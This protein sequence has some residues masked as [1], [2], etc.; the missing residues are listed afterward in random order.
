MSLC[1]IMRV[2]KRRRASVFGLQ[3]EANREAGDH[4]IDGRDFE[5]SDID[6]SRTSENVSL[7]HTDNWNKTI[8]STLHDLGIKERKDSVVLLD[9]LYTASPEFFEGKDREQIIDYFRECLDF[10]ER[11]YGKAINA[12]IHLDE[13]T[14]HLQ[15]ASIP[16]T[17][18]EKGYHLSAKSI[19]GGRA[20]Y[21]ARQDKFWNDVARH[22]GL[23][24]G[25]VSEPGK[26]KEH[27][28]VLAY[29]TATARTKAVEAE[30]DLKATE[31]RL[32]RAKSI[33]EASDASQ[34]AT[35]HR[36]ITGKE[37]MRVSPEAYRAIHDARSALQFAQ[38]L[39]R[40]P[41]A[42]RK[43]MEQK[44][45]K[46]LAVA[47]DDAERIRSEAEQVRRQ[48]EQTLRE[49]ESTLDRRNKKLRRY[50]RMERHWPE[51][52]K[53]MS[54]QL[55]ALDRERDNGLGR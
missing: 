42:Y 6:W 17:H 26:T 32:E 29:K 9:G 24:R 46:I 51:A 39:I 21:R 11:T 44:A 49:A 7:V 14:P 47:K 48:A 43:R 5:R 20:D 16:V 34:T 15:V 12:V 19:M 25:E 54:E 18:D 38:E 35:K 3:I 23:E 41:E 31:G 10:H 52:F 33:L 28:D 27:L 36:T 50:E 1:G 40:E 53:E 30:K 8:T 4:E 13:T 45:D 22:H 55:K 2:E 37:Y